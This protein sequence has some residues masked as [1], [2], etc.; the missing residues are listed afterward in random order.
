M[1]AL[2][3]L[4][5]TLF[6]ATSLRAAATNW[7]LFGFDPARSSFNSSERT[8]TVG[9]VHRLHERWQISLGAVA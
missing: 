1:S 5:A 3:A 8:L 7:P 9:N 4:A 6:C 2:C